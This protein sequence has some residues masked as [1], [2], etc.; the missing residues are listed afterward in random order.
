MSRRRPSRTTRECFTP[1]KRPYDTRE[2]AEEALDQIVSASR[3]GLK[4]PTR[5]YQCPA[6]LAW[7]LTSKE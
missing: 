2:A 3:H 1:W 4:I 7:H 5:S 6:C